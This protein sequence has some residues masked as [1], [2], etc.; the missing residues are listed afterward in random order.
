MTTET[1]AIIFDFGGVLIRWDPRNL[2]SRF[3]SK[4]RRWRI[5][6]KKSVLWNGT[7][8]RTRDAHLSKVLHRFQSNF[9]TAHI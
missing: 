6:W 8:N 5:F 1:K 9:H 3:Q 4:H 2:Y 7:H